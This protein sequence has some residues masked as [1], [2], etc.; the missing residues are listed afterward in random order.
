MQE[1]KVG[2]DTVNMDAG[3]SA[4]MCIPLTY[5]VKCMYICV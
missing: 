1:E 2:S 3:E 5:F 4:L